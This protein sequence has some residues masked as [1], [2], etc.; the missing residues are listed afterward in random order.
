LKHPIFKSYWAHRYYMLMLLPALAYLFVFN[1]VPM[2]GI[3][4]AFKD[5]Q[6]SKGIMGS[7]WVGFEVF[8]QLFAETSS[9][10]RVLRNTIVISGLKLLFVFPSALV[11]ALLINELRIRSIRKIAQNISYLP[12]FLSWVIIAS[13]IVEILSPSTGIVNMVLKHFGWE[14]IFFLGEP[15]WFLT[16][17]VASDIWQSA[18]W[19]SIIFLAAFTGI[20][21]ELYEAA[22]MDGAGRIRQ[23][24]S[25]TLPAISNII[26]IVFL[27]K[28]GEFLNA[29]FDQIFNLYNFR[30]YE[31]GDILDT[32]AYRT[33]IEEGNYS[34][35][36]AVSL[37]KNVLG[38]A[39]VLGAS[40]LANRFG[41][42]G[43]W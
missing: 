35:S 3:V 18:G 1:Y 29:G 22:Q 13:M 38:L 25:V 4:I 10:G 5:F 40:K 31:V 27:I 7:E 42:K 41:H 39:L 17:V 12:F 34:F 26:I 32:F 15:G 30:V 2:Y 6:I 23:I 16:I 21:P 36:T 14:P 28:I 19:N 43:L 11:L 9:F 8:K 20:N 37:F 33:G 24:F